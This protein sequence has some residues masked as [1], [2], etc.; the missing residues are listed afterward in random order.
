[1]ILHICGIYIKSKH[2]VTK[3]NQT[4]L[5]ADVEIFHYFEPDVRL[6]GDA[7]RGPTRRRLDALVGVPRQLLYGLNRASLSS[8]CVKGLEA[9]LTVAAVDTEGEATVG[10]DAIDVFTTSR[11]LCGNRTDDLSTTLPGGSFSM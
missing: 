10:D 1:M 7:A 8:S 6:L 2:R 3:R 9:L 4:I 5:S 11:I